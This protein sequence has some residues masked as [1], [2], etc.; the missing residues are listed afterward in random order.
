MS[1]P[2]TIGAAAVASLTGGTTGYFKGYLDS[3]EHH[4]NFLKT[5]SYWRLLWD[6]QITFYRQLVVGFLSGA[7]ESYLNSYVVNMQ[8]INGEIQNT[9]SNYF[10]DTEVTTFTSFLNQYII[11][12]QDFLQTVTNNMTKPITESQAAPLKSLNDQMVAALENINC[13]FNGAETIA[14]FYDFTLYL[15]QMTEFERIKDVNE[16]LQIYQNLQTFAGNVS[17]YFAKAINL[18]QYPIQK[19]I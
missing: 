19:W 18:S 1:V 10:S 7:S 2:V 12:F 17:I 6:K 9:L 11:V 4:Q 13:A 16:S 5:Q 14:L 8:T 3:N 15:L